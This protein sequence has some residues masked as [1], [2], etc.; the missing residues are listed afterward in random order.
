[1][2][3]KI[4]DLYYRKLIKQ[5]YLVE[6][7]E[8]NTLVFW[9]IIDVVLLWIYVSVTF[10]TIWISKRP[11]TVALFLNFIVI[12]RFCWGRILKKY[13]EIDEYFRNHKYEI[14]NAEDIFNRV[15]TNQIYITCFL[16]IV[17]I[18][19]FIEYCVLVYI[20]KVDITAMS[21]MLILVKIVLSIS[22]LAAIYD[23]G[24][25]LIERLFLAKPSMYIREELHKE[26]R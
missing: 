12:L 8:G 18:V 13:Y 1:M 2:V 6:N 14:I 25:A 3:K 10:Y 21:G 4:R 23:N 26:E 15:R 16:A 20:D 19:G 17:F 5:G 9:N 7:V 11:S 22:S 24:L